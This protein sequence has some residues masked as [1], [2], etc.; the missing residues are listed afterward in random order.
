[1]REQG[2]AVVI[3]GSAGG[4][5]ALSTI[6]SAL[7]ADFAMPIAIVLHV[8]EGSSGYLATYLDNNCALRVKEAD[9]KEP[10][11]VG[12]IYIAPAGYHL[13]IEGDKTL[14][15]SVDAPVLFARPSIDVL[16]ESA[17]DAYRDGL[18]GV[19]LT[20]GNSD[21]SQGLKKIQKM[22]GLTIAQDPADA[23]VDYMPRAAIQTTT[24]D[25]ILPLNTIAT[26]LTTLDRS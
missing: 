12:T 21:G 11:A 6:L 14:A 19:I 9:D 5:R 24:I 4:M 15:L 22:G 26:L 17:A 13:L 10:L 18:I 8:H 23:E 25:H 1:M 20:G 7:P 3:G 16:F 2:K